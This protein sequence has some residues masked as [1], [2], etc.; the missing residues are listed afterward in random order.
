MKTARQ[1][2]SFSVAVK[3][4]ASILDTSNYILTILNILCMRIFLR[5]DI[6]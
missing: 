4:I 2:V 1:P 6:V 5:D 3:I